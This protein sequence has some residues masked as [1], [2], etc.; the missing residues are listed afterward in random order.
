MAEMRQL[1]WTGGE[2]PERSV[3]RAAPLRGELVPRPS[4]RRHDASALVRLAQRMV[5][6]TYAAHVIPRLTAD[7]GPLA[8]DVLA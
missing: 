3:R 6:R 5:S 8:V 1:V 2:G 4:R 7:G